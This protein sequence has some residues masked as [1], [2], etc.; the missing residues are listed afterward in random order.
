MMENWEVLAACRTDSDVDAW[1]AG[2]GE[3]DRRAHAVQVCLSCPVRVECLAQALALGAAAG[4][5]W[6]ATSAEDRRKMRRQK[7]SA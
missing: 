7:V 6:A 4:G 3:H 1:F 2:P 5:T